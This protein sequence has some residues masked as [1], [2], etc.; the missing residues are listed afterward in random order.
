[1]NGKLTP[2]GHAVLSDSSFLFFMAHD[3]FN[4][5]AGFRDSSNLERGMV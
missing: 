3:V 5:R 2:E 4:R 1:M